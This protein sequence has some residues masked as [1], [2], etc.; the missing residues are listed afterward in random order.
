MARRRR[1]LRSFDGRFTQQGAGGPPDQR[2]ICLDKLLKGALI[3]CLGAT[4]DTAFLHAH[5]P[6]GETIALEPGL[7]LAIV[8]DPG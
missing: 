8:C 2:M 3:A 1:A 4:D 5:S 6:Q 7:A